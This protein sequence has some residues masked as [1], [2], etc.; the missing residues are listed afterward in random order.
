MMQIHSP[1]YQINEIGLVGEHSGSFRIRLRTVNLKPI[2]TGLYAKER[3]MYFH[4]GFLDVFRG[5]CTFVKKA[6]E[7]QLP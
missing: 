2:T 1:V 7:P 4:S 6:K 3:R 5:F